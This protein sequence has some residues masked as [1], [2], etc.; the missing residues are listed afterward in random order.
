[1]KAEDTIGDY[2][3]TAKVQNGRIMRIVQQQQ[4]RS[5]KACSE[6]LGIPYQTLNAYINFRCSP[7]SGSA[8]RLWKPSAV[9]IAK[10][11]GVLPEELWPDH[12]RTTLK[13][14]VSKYGDIDPA[15]LIRGAAETPL[16]ESSEDTLDIVRMVEQ[17]PER[18]AYVVSALYSGTATPKELAEKMNLSRARI[19]QM[20]AAGLRRLRRLMRGVP[21]KHIT[22][23]LDLLQ[24]VECMSCREQVYVP[25]PA[26]KD[27]RYMTCPRC[28]KYTLVGTREAL[29]FIL[30]VHADTEKKRKLDMVPGKEVEE[31]CTTRGKAVARWENPSNIYKIVARV[32]RKPNEDAWPDYEV[33]RVLGDATTER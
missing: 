19:G 1:M 14:T 18:E 11:L 29:Y 17:L 16:L 32:I 13:N 31:Y 24:T 27:S 2:Y 8:S 28:D 10:A 30:W 6:H 3:V 15:L 9:K 25:L 20:E 22:D 21:H 26:G 5:V 7:I 4:F 33:V 23:M 12:M